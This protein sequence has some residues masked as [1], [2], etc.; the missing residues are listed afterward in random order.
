[1]KSDSASRLIA[2]EGFGSLAR[3][4]GGSGGAIAVA[5]GRQT[6]EPGRGTGIDCDA[7][8]FAH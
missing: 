1:M 4:G 3:I 6:E 5:G 8:N 2:G 7:I